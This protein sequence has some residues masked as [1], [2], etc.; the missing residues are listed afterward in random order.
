ME[1][2][3]LDLAAEAVYKK[4]DEVEGD[5]TKL[6]HVLQPVAI[7][8]TVQAMIDN[9]G[10]RYIFENDFPHT[11]PYSVFS[12]A[13]REIGAQAAA[14]KLDRAVALFPFDH[15]EMNEKKR[16]EFMATL[17][18]TSELFTLGDEVCGDESVWQQMEE[19]VAK[20]SDA[21]RQDNN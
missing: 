16:N 17:A 2:S 7:L 11:P 14:D 12:N 1:K 21:F 10:F 4:L 13:Y 8:Y 18:E 5:P 15:P 20:H 6:P 19:Y 3:Q 9:G